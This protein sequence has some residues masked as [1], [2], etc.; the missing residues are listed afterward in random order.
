VASGLLAAVLWIGLPAT[1]EAATPWRSQV[2]DAETGQPLADVAVIGVWHRRVTGYP[3]F[4]IGPTGIVGATET[5]TDAAGRFTLPT[6][7]FP[8]SLG[9]GVGPEIGEPELGLF[10]AGYG[11]WRLRDPAA[12]SAARDGVIEM[13]P[14]W[15]PDERR[16]YLAGAW[17]REERARLR[18]GWL[19]AEAPR[20]W[21]D[22]PYREAQGY[23]AAINR[24]RGALG[25]PPIGIGYP[26]L[27][28]KY[29]RPAP[30][31]EGPEAARLRGA[32]AVVIDAAGLRY[33]ADTEHH[34]IVV[35]DESGAMVRTWGRFGRE[36]GAFQYPRGLALDRAGMI[37]V[38]DWGNHRIQRFAPDGRFLGEFG[39]LRFEDFDGLFDPTDVA[40]PDTG[41]IVVYVHARDV[42]T[43]TPEGRRLRGWRLPFP[44]APRCGIAVDPAGHLYVVGDQDRRVHKLDAAGRVLASFGGGRGEGDGQLFDPIGLA[45]D[46]AGRVY[47]ADWL[48]ERGRVHAFAP[49]GRLLGTWSVRDDGQRLRSPQGLAVDADGGLHVVD[50]SLPRLV[51]ITPD[52]QNWLIGPRDY[53]PTLPGPR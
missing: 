9:I 30:P 25:F 52:A 18:T 41:E 50:R 37:Y 2:V 24:E 33:V 26:E 40:A 28:T 22:L 46:S 34:R 23:E 6:R 21:I 51:T 53:D 42:Y 39:G 1:G 3:A 47:V 32:S 27:W 14:L 15:S 36:P 7:F 19:H 20:N 8:G 38:A 11:G 10:V 12:W 43:F 45:V 5:T 16:Q 35:F 44:A 29:L 31:S 17:T 49:D 4:F 48:R 13:R